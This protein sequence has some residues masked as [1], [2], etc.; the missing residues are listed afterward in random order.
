MQQEKL[1]TLLV[2]ILTGSIVVGL[3]VVAYFVFLKKDVSTLSS[4]PASVA[5]TARIAEET[6]LIGTEIDYTMR[7]LSDL[8]RAV[9]SSN[10]IFTL[11]AFKNLQDFTITVYPEA[12]GRTNPFLPTA[13]KIK[14][15]ELESSFKKSAPASSSATPSKTETSPKVETPTS[16]AGNQDSVGASLGLDGGFD[17]TTGD[18]L[19]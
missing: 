19:P 8:S 16:G 4:V 3:V 12:V 7:D 5:D 10:A 9:S 6:A 17:I 1:K 11:P 13:W 14:M 18:I 15:K 2:N